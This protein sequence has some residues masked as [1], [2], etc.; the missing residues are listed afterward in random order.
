VKKSLKILLICILFIGLAAGST[1]LFYYLHP[2]KAVHLILP[3]LNNINYLSADIRD[4]TA[5]TKLK[6]VVQ[7]KSPYRLVIDT[8]HF[9][10]KLSGI[11]VVEETVAVRLDL[12]KS[13][14]DTIALHAHLPVKKIREII[15]KLQGTDSTQ[16]NVNAYIIYNTVWGKTKLN[17][18]KEIIIAVPIPPQ[19]KVISIEKKK[20]AVSDKTLTAMARIEIINKGK[21]LDIELSDI[22]YHLIIKDILHSEGT[23]N[24]KISIPPRS[25]VYI[26]IPITIELEHPMK[27]LW[28]ITLDKDQVNYSLFIKAELKH[29]KL[30]QENFFPVEFHSTGSVE[31]KEKK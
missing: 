27:T 6:V 31:L 14:S 26:D 23:I 15:G 7:N 25:N 28:L 2:K 16:I 5:F 10:I 8:V 22:R 18:D 29:H 17:V 9:Q 3:D 4:D 24:H 11:T 30:D 20:Y 21:V 19:V 12:L 1:A 13:Q